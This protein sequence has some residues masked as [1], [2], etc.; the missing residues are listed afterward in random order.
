MLSSDEG[1][2]RHP[3]SY[4]SEPPPNKIIFSYQQSSTYIPSRYFEH[5]D[6]SPGSLFSLHPSTTTT[7]QAGT[8][9]C[10]YSSI[11]PWKKGVK[12]PST[13]F[14]GPNGQDAITDDGNSACG[15][16]CKIVQTRSIAVQCNMEQGEH[17]V[18]RE[19]S[20]PAEISIQVGNGKGHLGSQQ[21]CILPREKQPSNLPL[22]GSTNKRQC[23]D[24]VG[25]T[26]LTSS[27]D[28]V[29]MKSL[30]TMQTIFPRAPSP[31]SSDFSPISPQDNLEPIIP[32]L[33][34][35]LSSTSSV[36][37]NPFSSNPGS[38]GNNIVGG[39]T[40]NFPEYPAA[41]FTKVFEQILAAEFGETIFLQLPYFSI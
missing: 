29:S 1:A 31:P 32:N 7:H 38:V 39:K 9:P 14:S 5:L 6:T 12:K 40:F 8:Y 27:I 22:N 16:G 11:Y 13:K 18:E 28:P 21:R 41:E 19:P 26:R 25:E 37:P 35:T 15:C 3:H 30:S 36:S 4:Y 34:P 33:D 10:T 24:Q 17:I 23:I 20:S 2:V